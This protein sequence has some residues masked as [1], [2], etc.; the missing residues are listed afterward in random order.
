MKHSFTWVRF[1][2]PFSRGL[3]RYTSEMVVASNLHL[4]HTSASEVL[5]HGQST[6]VLPPI[7]RVFFW[8]WKHPIQEELCTMPPMWRIE[9]QL[10]WHWKK[11]PLKAI[12]CKDYGSHEGQVLNECS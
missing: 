1:I 3:R 6:D 8:N 12:P 11:W 10:L 5:G 4:K 2:P 7:Q 9:S